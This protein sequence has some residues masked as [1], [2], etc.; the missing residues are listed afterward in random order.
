MS[1]QVKTLVGPA[2]FPPHPHQL[3]VFRRKETA[4][5]MAVT[6]VSFSP[7]GNLAVSSSADGAVTLWDLREKK[8]V[9]Q[10]A[11]HNGPSSCCVFASD[12]RNVV[13]GGWDKLAFYSDSGYTSSN[14]SLSGCADWVTAVDV[15]PAR[16]LVAA[17]SWDQSVRLWTP[18]GS[19]KQTL[20]GHTAPISSVSF[21][22]HGRQLASASYD[23]AIKLW[24]ADSGR[25]ERTLALHRGRVHALAYAPDGTLISGGADLTVKFWDTQR[26]T[27]RHEFVT[28]GGA[29]AVC[30]RAPSGR[31]TGVFGDS[32]GN[33]YLATLQ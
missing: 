17:G 7:D 19:A 16:T 5:E 23:G 1:T 11:T 18:S 15:N 6:G 21:A 10:V 31:S 33:L 4:Q 32:I 12:G 9:R 13:S 20:L 24:Q 28:Q 3:R 30:V 14:R 25:L 22:P 27:V 8:K 2:P 29:T 26:G